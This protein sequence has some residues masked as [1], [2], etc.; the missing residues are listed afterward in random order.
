MPKIVNFGSGMGGFDAVVHLAE[1]S[2]DPLGQNQQEITFQIN[3][4]GS[5]RL[6]KL[7]RE[8]SIRRFV[9]AVTKMERR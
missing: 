8:A 6:A 2:N 9:R 4:E 3:H 1:I 7:A 5:V